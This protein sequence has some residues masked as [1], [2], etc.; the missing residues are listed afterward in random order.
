MAIKPLKTYKSILAVDVGAETYGWCFKDAI[1]EESGWNHTESY[2]NFYK[3]IGGLITLYK[4]EIIVTGKINTGG[5]I[6]LNLVRSH[7]SYVGLLRL[8]AEKA[9]LERPIEINDTSAR[10]FL[11]PGE[12]RKKI[13]MCKYY[14]KIELDQM[15]AIILATA[16]WNSG[17]TLHIK[18]P[19]KKKKSKV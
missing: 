1:G 6:S 19:S 4:P 14:P 5:I 3:Q 8:L 18:K 9:G 11:H 17:F 13:N 2:T 12:G 16:W 10:A 7:Y 15:D